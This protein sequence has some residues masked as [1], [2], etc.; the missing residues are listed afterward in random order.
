M[1]DFCVSLFVALPTV[2]CKPSIHFDGEFIR[3]RRLD[4]AE[5]NLVRVRFHFTGDH[6]KRNAYAHS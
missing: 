1:L 4:N 5:A 2:I 3:I 6:E